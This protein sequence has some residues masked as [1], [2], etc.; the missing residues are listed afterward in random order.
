[1]ASKTNAVRILDGL[2][3]R[4]E[5]VEYEVHPEDLSA[6]RVAEQIGLPIEQVWKTLLVRGDRNG[7]AFAVIPGDHTLDLKALAQFTGDRRVEPVPLKELRGLTGYVRGGVT[8]LGARKAFPVFVD[9]LVT[10]HDLI[11]VSAGRRGLQIWL[12]P[13][14]YLSAVDGTLAD[15]AVSK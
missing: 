4:Y 11:S 3:V 7:P 9:E 13:D 10:I 2:G 14:A 5:L 12:H 15:I 1:M 6:E 8:V